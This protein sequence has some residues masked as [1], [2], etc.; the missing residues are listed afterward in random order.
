[1]YLVIGKGLLREATVANTELTDKNLKMSTKGS[2]KKYLT[3]K[4]AL[5]T[6]NSLS[7]LKLQQLED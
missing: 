6:V 1:M 5:K 3:A 7:N 4:K 2:T